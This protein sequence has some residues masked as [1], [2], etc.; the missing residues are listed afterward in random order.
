M[1][2]DTAGCV[3]PSVRAADDMAPVSQTV[4]KISSD[5]KS[6][7]RVGEGSRMGHSINNTYIAHNA[8]P[9]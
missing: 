8:V 5:L 9:F 3:R 1:A 7:G 4:R 6:N 2:S